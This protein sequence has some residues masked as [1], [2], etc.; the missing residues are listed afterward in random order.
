MVLSDTGKQLEIKEFTSKKKHL[1]KTKGL[2]KNVT[3]QGRSR[4]AM[5]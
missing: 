3:S 2:I 1:S 4:R 5:E